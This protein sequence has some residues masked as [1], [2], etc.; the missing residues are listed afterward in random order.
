[1]VNGRMPYRLAG[2]MVAPEMISHTRPVRTISL[3]SAWV[4]F[5]Q[6]TGDHC[7]ASIIAANAAASCLA[8]RLRVVSVCRSRAPSHRRIL[9]G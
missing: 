7:F 1:M 5:Q 3:S 2:G 6:D 9:P 4:T 8:R